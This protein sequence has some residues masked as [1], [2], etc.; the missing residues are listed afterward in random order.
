MTEE[1]NGLEKDLWEYVLTAGACWRAAKSQP[2]RAQHWEGLAQAYSN[3]AAILL[4]HDA[5]SWRWP[6]TTEARE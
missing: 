1:W 4:G 2:A 3:R 5:A 6:V